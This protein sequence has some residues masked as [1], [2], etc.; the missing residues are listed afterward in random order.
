MKRK[1]VFSI[2]AGSALTVA[3]GNR[4][5]AAEAQGPVAPLAW[6][7]KSPIKIAFV[8]GKGATV[9]DF[10]GPWE[11]FQD[12]MLTTGPGPNDAVMP[13][14][15]VMVSDST[16]PLQAT[17]GMII[18]PHFSYST[19][20]EQP[21]II[22]MGAQGEHTAEK[23]AW[24]KQAAP[25]AQVVMSVCTGAFLLAKTG[26]LDGLQATTHHDFYDSFA[27][28]FPAVHLV[29]GP[30]FVDNG[31][32]ATAGGLTSGIELALYI[33][34]RYMGNAA[35]STTAFYMEYNRSPERPTV[36]S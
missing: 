35:A 25:G 36:A 27:Q 6:D 12:A 31:K 24:I 11:V 3:L 29:R 10:A 23:I 22:V 1:D 15:T 14:R 21:D 34:Q 28:K 20:P 13:F 7:R 5:A 17:N 8:V 18:T 9:I 30:R 16:K 4:V 2:A 32:F 26:L 19:V 33:V